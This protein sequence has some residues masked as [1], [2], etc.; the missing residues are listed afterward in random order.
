MLIFPTILTTFIEL[1]LRHQYWSH[2]DMYPLETS[3]VSQVT[4]EELL[5]QLSFVYVDAATS[6]TS[7][8]VW[9]E[10]QCQRF[11]SILHREYFRN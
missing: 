11:L 2:I 7:T 9:S 6:Q 10:E 1:Q 8:S 4:Y 5:E 3:I